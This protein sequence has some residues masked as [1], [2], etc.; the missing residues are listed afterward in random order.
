M[1]RL[2]HGHRQRKLA[3]YLSIL[4]APSRLTNTRTSADKCY[5]P[6]MILTSQAPSNKHTRLGVQALVAKLALNSRISCSF[7]MTP[8]LS[9]PFSQA[10]SLTLGGVL[11]AGFTTAYLPK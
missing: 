10:G 11:G 7:S 9:K 8:A 5:L 4:S 1:T 2:Y 3:K 6:D